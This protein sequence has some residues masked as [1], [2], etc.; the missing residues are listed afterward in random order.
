[1]IIYD[2]IGYLVKDAI[3]NEDLTFNNHIMNT[4]IQII[5]L[6]TTFLPFWKITIDEVVKGHN[7]KYS[8]RRKR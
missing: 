3:S 7:K 2:F 5:N 8:R 6:L 4:T 1:L